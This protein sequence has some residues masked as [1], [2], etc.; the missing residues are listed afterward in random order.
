MAPPAIR[1]RTKKKIIVYRD[2]I[3]PEKLKFMQESID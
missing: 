3:F 1:N 2:D